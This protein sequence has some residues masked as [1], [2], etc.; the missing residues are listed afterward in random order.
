MKLFKKIVA[1]FVNWLNHSREP[2]EHGL[3]DFEQIRYHIRP[4]DILLVEGHSRA[5]KVLRSVTLSRWTHCALYI[6]RLIDITDADLKTM[7]T[8]FFEGEPDTQLVIESKLGQGIVIYPLQKYEQDHIRLCRPKSLNI[9]DA[10]QVLR[11]A[12]NRLGVYRDGYYIFDLARFFFPWGLL[13]FRWRLSLFPR[14]P[15]RHTKNVSAAFIAE[16][17]G[18]IQFPVYPLVKT[19]SDQG[20][21]LWRRHPR[22]CMPYEI[23]LSPNFEVVKYP[24]ID[25]KHY[26]SERLIPWKGSGVYTGMEM[27][28]TLTLK[29][30]ENNHSS[31][32]SEKLQIAKPAK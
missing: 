24:F 26:D 8:H 18:F 21:Q 5:E 17:F 2:K 11:F 29:A 12:I 13:P 16:S 9:K 25:F 31:Q 32:K 22:L 7:I 19:T 23:D 30:P 20:V 10:E 28:P 27:D 3:S 6:G 15:G 1:F 4:C 14:W